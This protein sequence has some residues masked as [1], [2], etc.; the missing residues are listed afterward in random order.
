[1]T[2]HANHRPY[3][4][5]CALQTHHFIGRGPCAREAAARQLDRF[6]KR[7]RAKHSPRDIAAILALCGMLGPRYGAP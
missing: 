3:F 2:K 1:M 5:M 6:W 7:E 4:A